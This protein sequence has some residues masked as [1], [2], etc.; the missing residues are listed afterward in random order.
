[1]LSPKKTG[2]TMKRDNTYDVGM[3]LGIGSVGWCV[4]N[5]DE[6]KLIDMG[7]RIFNQA[8]EAKEP[9]IYRSARRTL[10]RKKWRKEQLKKAFNDFGIL[11]S[12]EINKKDYLSFTADNDDIKRP[13][14]ATVYHLRKRSLNEKVSK[15][16]LFLALY[17]ICKTRGHFLMETTDFE[18]DGITFEVF[19]DKTYEFLDPL[20]SIKNKNKLEDKLLKP[21]FDGKIVKSS[22]I[23]STFNSNS[24]A[25]DEGDDEIL[26]TFANA[27]CGFKF[28]ENTIDSNAES[29]KVN[30]QELKKS[31]TLSE[32]EENLVE[33]HDI[34]NI[35]KI[36]SGKNNY[37]CE[38]A[39]DKIDTYTR[40]DQNRYKS[41][42]EYEAYIKELNK[43][44]ANAKK[45]KTT[46]KKIHIRSLKNLDNG[47]PNGLYVKEVSAILRKQQEFYPEITDAFIEVCTSIVSARIPYYVGPLSDNA[48]NGWA[49]INKGIEYSYAY[50]NMSENQSDNSIDEFESIKRWKERMVSHCKYLPECPAL[51]KGSFIGETFSII[52]E[53]NNYEAID[54]N[55]N[56]YYLTF[57]D[58][59]KIFNELFLIQNGDIALSDVEQ[60]LNL[61]KFGSRSGVSKKFNNKYTIYNNIANIFPELRVFD[62]TEIF[63]D[64]DK[65]N[66]L[67]E[68]VL[69][70]NLFDEEASK[71]RY[72]ES[73]GYGDFFSEQLAKIK[74]NGFFNLSKEFILNQKMNEEGDNLL[75]VL[76]SDNTS[77]HVNNMSYIINNIYDSDGNKIDYSANKY[78]R[79]LKN[80]ADLDISLLLQNGKPLIPISRPVIRAL[81]EAMKTYESIIDVYGVPKRLV[82]ETAR[83][84]DSIKDFTDNGEIGQKHVDKMDNLCGYLSRQLDENKKASAF[85]KEYG[86]IESWDNLKSQYDRNKEKIELYIRQN[87]IDLLTGKSISIIH[88][89]DYEIDHILPRGFGDDSMDDKMLVEKKANAKK[90]DRLPIEFLESPDA[91]EFTSMTVSRFEEMVSMLFDMH[92]ISENKKK[93][94]LL[95]NSNDVEIFVNQNLVDTRYIIREFMSILN[96]YNKIKGYNTHIVAMKAAFTNIYRNAFGIRKERDLGN[97]HHALDAATICLTDRTLSTYFPNYDQRGNFEAYER[98]LKEIIDAEQANGDTARNRNKTKN[99]ILYAYSVAYGQ[100]HNQDGSLLDQIKSMTPLFSLKT[101]KNYRGAFTEA[102]LHSPKEAKAGD[103]LDILGI[104]NDKRAYSGV[105][106]AA[107]DYYKYTDKKGRRTHLAV[108]IP[109]FI[110]NSD[111]SID[112]TKY[113]KMVTEYYKAPELLDENGELK[114]KLFRFR[115]FRNDIIYDTESYS[116]VIFNL[117]SIANK[118]TEIKQIY[119]FSYKDLYGIGNEI[120][121]HLISRFSIK[122]P[123]NDGIEFID[124]NKAE[125]INYVHE[126]LFP[127][128]NYDRYINTLL[129]KMKDEKN[130][131]R[132]CYRLVYYISIANRKNIP[133]MIDDRNVTTANN[134]SIKMN[135]DA[136]YI[137]LKYHHLG[138]RFGYND[139]GTLLIEGPKG[140]PNAFKKI[141]REKFSWKMSK[142]DVE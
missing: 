114:D 53:L 112:K 120:K 124:L 37:L 8:K 66:A 12:E 39:V 52:N 20:L 15:R 10:R 104:N 74:S 47:Y 54:N 136:E 95:A 27:I 110:I 41:P 115:A 71:R 57:N 118:K 132:F 140:K 4:I 30:V 92:L 6:A 100:R 141:K 127:I 83:G 139:K 2:G 96:A 58:K 103:V 63:N 125:L 48:K 126:N 3:D 49:V 17:N 89:E 7:V 72:F 34:C 62:I 23:K 102:T 31:D 137:K 55:N 11:S 61:K 134:D 68:I 29:K 87:G 128:E 138:L 129:K 70:I 51:P 59:I 105:E 13:E 109:K 80:G 67:E 5:Q 26:L 16:E 36:L 122:T 130:L 107:V 42:E 111:G 32:L 85:F 46:N 65:I 44:S 38:V 35:A 9:R 64:H 106:C 24:F 43:S 90:S 99:M 142:Y 117:G 84:K 75:G 1:M 119:N 73:L 123:R 82:I 101:E 28:D 86:K 135:P 60:L 45:D 50:S 81:N 133:P 108:H 14:D 33:L 94:L 93:R 22:E 97:Q 121:G 25:S 40:I 113:L 91:R 131:D 19:K 69:N 98:F 21:I 77:D 76:F 56:S 18:R 78:E 116:P 88:L 79:M